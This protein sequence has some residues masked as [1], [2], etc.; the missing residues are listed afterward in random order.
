MAENT[1]YSQLFDPIPEL[2]RNDADITVALLNNNMVPVA[3]VDGP[4]S[5]PFFSATKK[6]LPKV[7]GYYWPDNPI[8][9]IGCIE[10]YEFAKA[11]SDDW[12]KPMSL[13]DATQNTTFIKEL[14]KKQ[15]AAYAA[16]QWA[17][18]QAGGVEKVL[19][20]LG[21]DALKAK[22]DPGWRDGAQNP[23]P[24]DQWKREVEYW[25]K[26]GLAKVQLGVVNLALG[27]SDPKDHGLRDNSTFVVGERQDLFEILCAS[28]KVHSLEF[29]NL[30]RA[31]FI[32]LAVLGSLSIILPSLV[33]RIVICWRKR[34]EDVLTWTSYGQLQLQRMAA[35]GAGVQGWK[36]GNEDVPLLDPHD[37]PSGDVDVRNL[38]ADG[39]PH[40]VWA[41]SGANPSV[42]GGSVPR[43][44]EEYQGHHRKDESTEVLLDVI[45][46]LNIRQNSD[47]SMQGGYDKAGGWGPL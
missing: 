44:Y 2:R 20:I 4:C 21:A 5:D 47:H 31:G 15:V 14:S 40:P 45:P 30:H 26:I 29:K 6:P 46:G 35:E 13:S 3:G 39:L 19:D 18:G 25:F 27:P 24:N 22:K 33:L 11:G 34:K 17:T 28:Q 8:T 38:G 7:P 12:G 41:W 23:L 1:S 32:S 16:I 42:V 37:Q 9:G 36:R 10:Q 43:P